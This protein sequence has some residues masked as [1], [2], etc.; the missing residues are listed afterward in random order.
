MKWIPSS[1]VLDKLEDEEEDGPCQTI[2][3]YLDHIE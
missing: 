1:G 2:V 3:I